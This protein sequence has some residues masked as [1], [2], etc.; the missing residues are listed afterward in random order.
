M[1]G[2]GTLIVF[3]FPRVGRGLRSGY[4]RE[5]AAVAASAGAFFQYKAVAG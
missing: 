2:G 4:H 3:S 1:R 5:E